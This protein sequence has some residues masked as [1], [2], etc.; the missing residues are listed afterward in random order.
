MG[1]HSIQFWLCILSE[2]TVSTDK[3]IDFI[4]FSDLINN[5]DISDCILKLFPLY[6]EIK[7]LSILIISSPDFQC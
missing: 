4:S 1:I 2:Y 5:S 6:N 3:K 7:Q